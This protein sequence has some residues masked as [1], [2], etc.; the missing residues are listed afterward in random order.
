MIPMGVAI[1]ATVSAFILGI[2]AGFVVCA[3]LTVGS[4]MDDLDC[5]D[6]VRE[7]YGDGSLYNHPG[8]RE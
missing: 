2:I 7:P 3:M 4:R 6:A 8:V 5:E 1:A